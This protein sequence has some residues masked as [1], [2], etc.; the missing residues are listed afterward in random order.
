M[1]EDPAVGDETDPLVLAAAIAAVSARH[2]SELQPEDLLDPDRRVVAW[3]HAQRLTR[4][5]QVVAQMAESIDRGE[6]GFAPSALDEAP[7]WLASLRALRSVAPLA[8][9]DARREIAVQHS[10]RD[11]LDDL[12][13]GVDD[14]DGAAGEAAGGA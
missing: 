13:A 11:Q 9:I 8:A 2:L 14:D 1:R 3:A 5:G 6:T 12:R 4:A 10:W 7:G